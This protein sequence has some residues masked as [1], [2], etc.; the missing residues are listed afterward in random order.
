[1]TS[2]LALTVPSPSSQLR[3]SLS[4]RTLKRLEN[5]HKTGVNITLLFIKFMNNFYPFPLVGVV[6]VVME[7]VVLV[8]IAM[9]VE[10]VVEQ[11]QSL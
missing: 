5:M 4:G 7:I 8:A 11:G 2:F 1:M 3:G 6:V 10:V 9:M